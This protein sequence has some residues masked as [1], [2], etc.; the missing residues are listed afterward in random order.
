MER[1]VVHHR[2]AGDDSI[3]LFVGKDMVQRFDIS[4]MLPDQ[5]SEA[6]ALSIDWVTAPRP[7]TSRR[8]PEVKARVV[9]DTRMS[10]RVADYATKMTEYAKRRKEQHRIAR[11]MEKKRPR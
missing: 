1:Q 7:K 4:E 11:E 8:K 6:M 2:G 3:A 5:R 10:E 9:D